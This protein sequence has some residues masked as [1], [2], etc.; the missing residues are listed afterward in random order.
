M[1]ITILIQ[2]NLVL[3]VPSTTQIAVAIA[4]IRRNLNIIALMKKHLV[5]KRNVAMIAL[6]KRNF[7]THRLITTELLDLPW[8]S[9]PHEDSGKQ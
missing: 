6:I 4:L 7:V 9:Q 2:R 5:L 3:Y 1:I 8:I